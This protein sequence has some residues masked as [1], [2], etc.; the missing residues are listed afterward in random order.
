MAAPV[1]LEKNL[2]QSCRHAYPRRQRSRSTLTFDPGVNTHAERL[3]CTKVLIARA[4]F[5]LERGRRDVQA[6]TKVT[7]TDRHNC[8]VYYLLSI[9]ILAK[10]TTE[11]E[12]VVV[13]VAGYFNQKDLAANDTVGC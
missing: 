8:S 3:P 1:Q 10:T 4:V 6:D 5:L 12:A 7:D 9:I 2:Q 11:T 13:V